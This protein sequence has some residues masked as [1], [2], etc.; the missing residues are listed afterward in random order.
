MSSAGRSSPWSGAAVGRAATFVL[1]TA[2]V[3]VA[4]LVFLGPGAL[5]PAFAV[6]VY[7]APAD[8]ARSLALRLAT[9][10]SLYDVDEPA[11][12]QDLLV[13][14]SAPGQT[15]R[16]WHGPT[17]PD[18]G[19]AEARLEG[20]APLRGPVAIG[21]TALGA[22]PR[23]LAA[24]EIPLKLADPAFVK[25]GRLQGTTRGDL[26][27]HVDALRGFLASP[28][29]ETLR[30]QVSPPGAP[31]SSCPARASTRRLPP[32]PPTSAASPCSG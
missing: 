32:P 19:T 24:G 18:D 17:A 10:K 20:S 30:V 23:L 2:S 16:A 28:F 22:K 29:P 8:G 13:E 11:G 12:T 26:S 31:R 14:A 1:P 27:I 6:R 15:L 21:V 4:A 25:L 5:R 7:G 3:L 9:V